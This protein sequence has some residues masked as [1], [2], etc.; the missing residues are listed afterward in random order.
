MCS[1]GLSTTLFGGMDDV[2]RLGCIGK[3]GEGWGYSGVMELWVI[4]RE[5][6]EQR[7]ISVGILCVSVRTV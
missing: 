3:L 1:Q 7:V 5:L 4:D 2:A 6:K